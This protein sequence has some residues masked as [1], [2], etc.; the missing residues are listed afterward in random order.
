VLKK[1]ISDKQLYSYLN[2]GYTDNPHNNSETFFEHCMSLPHA[3]Y[4]VVDT[5]RC[6]VEKTVCYYKINREQVVDNNTNKIVEEFTALLICSVERRLRSDVAVGSSLSGGLDSSVIVNIIDKL[7]KERPEQQH[8]FSA[9]FPGYEKDERKYID[10]IAASTHV[11]PHFVTPTADG[12]IADFEKLCYHQESPFG[13]A[14]IYAQ[15]CVMKLAKEQNVTVLLDGQGADEVLG[16]YPGYFK[17]FF[18]ELKKN[19]SNNY[20]SQLRSFRQLFNRT[21]NNVF[22]P[23]AFN[24]RLSITAPGLVKQLRK[25]KHV[26]SDIGNDELNKDFIK[27]F[28]KNDLV[29]YSNKTDL[30]EQ[31]LNDTMVTGGLQQLLRYA[32]RNSMAHSREVRLPFLSHELVDLAFGLPSQFKINDGWTKWL[33]RTAFANVL[34][35]EICWRVNKIGFAAPQSSWM[36]SAEIAAYTMEAKTQLAKL[37]ILEKRKISASHNNI[38]NDWR[39][40]QVMEL[41]K[42]V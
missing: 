18:T 28:D 7:I 16:G 13:S 37:G 21:A 23:K 24:Y 19:K 9:V 12:F 25:L 36:Q 29:H 6:S 10:L 38:D 20:E 2:F 31:L 27:A 17:T 26:F 40:L 35:K 14:S 34:P 30:N 32:D 41:I 22:N 42:I 8:S 5:Q 39:Y 33:L 11:T 4:M 15:Y 3:H 1:K